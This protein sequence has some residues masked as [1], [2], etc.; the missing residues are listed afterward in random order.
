MQLSRVAARLDSQF[1]M[2]DDPG[3]LNMKSESGFSRL[4]GLA[5]AGAI[6]IAGLAGGN[7]ARAASVGIP[8][9]ITRGAAFWSSV[10]NNTS[11]PSSSTVT[12]TNGDVYTSDMTAFGIQDATLSDGS[13]GTF[14]DGVDNALILAVNGNLFVNPDTTV[15]LTGDTLTTDT[16]TIVPG[17]DAQIRYNFFPG[18]PVVRGLFSL[19]N[20]TAAP[21]SVNAAILGDYGSDSNTTVRATS[22][23]DT[24]I[25]NSDFWY[26]T[27]D[28][29]AP[30]GPN[31]PT[32]DRSKP[33]GASSPNAVLGSPDPRITLSRYGAGATVVPLNALTPGIAGPSQATFGLRYPVTIAAGQTVRIMVVMEMSD[34]TVSEAAAA[35]A[36]A[37]FESLDA[38]QTAG[39][40]TG[41]TPTE[42]SQLINYG[43][44]G[45]PPPP[46]TP[47]ASLPTATPTGL[48]ALLAAL[49]GLGFFE[50][51]RRKK[52]E[53]TR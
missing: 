9:N 22:D 39:L 37:D 32:I 14:S 25:E 21:I 52:L 36:A 2:N 43:Q 4:K 19:T 15:D 18:R 53:T 7:V 45:G 5:T 31:G 11:F 42:Q 35:A 27:D 6:G 13:G 28:L 12:T 16:V 26:I 41:L 17:V 33:H 1:E 24:T 8:I 51:R 30:T 44:S 46:A 20:T 29:S 34:P 10:G 3:C 47:P 49:G 23:G 38:L 40:L 48:A 50:L